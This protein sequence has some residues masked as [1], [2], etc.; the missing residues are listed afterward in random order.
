MKHRF[1][2]A[3]AWFLIIAVAVLCIA[4]A[5]TIQPTALRAWNAS[6][7]VLAALCTLIVFA[8][9]APDFSETFF[10]TVRARIRGGDRLRLTCTL[11]I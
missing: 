3:F 9:S 1:Q 6:L 8:L 5:Y 7:G 11:L 4:P 10:A 2:I